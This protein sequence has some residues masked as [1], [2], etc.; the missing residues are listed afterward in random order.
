MQVDFNNFDF[1]VF[2]CDGVILDS[3][4]LKTTAFSKSLP[5]YPLEK[6]SKFIDYHKAN[7]GISRYKKFDHFFKEIMQIEHRE[8]LI[9]QALRNYESYIFEK[10]LSCNFV[11]GVEKFLNHLKRLGKDAYV[12]SGSSENELLKIFRHRKIDNLFCNVLGSPST[13]KEN[14]IKILEKRRDYEKGLF[15]GDSKIDFEVAHQ[16]FLNFIFV[17]G[18]SEWKDVPDKLVTINDFRDINF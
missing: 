6:V 12:N 17:K 8:D 7:G 3:N 1:F 13:K 9:L 5:E 16:F 11:P 18:F 14:M 15:F 4:L 2:D 10:L